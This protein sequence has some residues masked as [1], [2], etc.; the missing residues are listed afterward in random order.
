[1]RLRRETGDF[2]IKN[3]PPDDEHPQ[4][5]FKKIRPNLGVDDLVGY[6]VNMP[7][8][9]RSDVSTGKF[10]YDSAVVIAASEYNDLNIELCIYGMANGDWGSNSLYYNPNTGDV[11]YDPF[12]S[13]III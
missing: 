11:A 6:M 10:V 1:M 4:G 7:N 12:T 8:A 13:G 2:E 3:L 5:Y 9:S